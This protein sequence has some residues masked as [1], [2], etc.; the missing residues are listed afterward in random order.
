MTS[1]DDPSRPLRTVEFAEEVAAA[2][3]YT[4][5]GQG[6]QTSSAELLAG[7]MAESPP[8]RRALEVRGLSAAALEGTAGS[9]RPTTTRPRW[10]RRRSSRELKQVVVTAASYAMDAREREVAIPRLLEAFAAQPD[11]DGARRLAEAGIDAS[12]LKKIADELR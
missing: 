7:M 9:A 12:A 4:W 8:L 5:G 1:S 11:S 2:Q 3:R 6:T 10:G